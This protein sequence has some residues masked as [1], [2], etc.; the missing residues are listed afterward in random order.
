MANG[1]L[2]H[3]GEFIS[4]QTDDGAERITSFRKVPNVVTTQG[5]WY[6]LS[7]SAGNPI[8]NYYAASPLKFTTLTQSVDKGIFHGGNVSPKRKYIDTVTVMCNTAA[9]LPMPVILMD[10]IGFYPFIDEGSTDE[11]LM[12]NSVSPTRYTDGSGVQIMAI[13]QAARTGGQTFSVKYTNSN[14]VSG[15]VSQ[16]VI[17]NTVS[18][19]GNIVTSDKAVNR[20]CLF[21]PLA[22]G[23]T[24]VRYIESVTMN[25]ADVGLFAL[26]LVKPL[27]TTQVFTLDCPVETQTFKDRV[28]LPQVVDD[29]YLN[30]ICLP[31]GSLSGVPVLGTIKFIFN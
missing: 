28:S 27:Y 1:T 19:N 8:P 11:Q 20:A 23:D 22:D 25:G 24:G 17:Q 26:V 21:I 31:N 6:D 30:M 10:Y 4:C 2:Q 7:Y 13:S 14:G 3:F 5:I 15:R 29:A 16:T 12:D 18:Q 9:A